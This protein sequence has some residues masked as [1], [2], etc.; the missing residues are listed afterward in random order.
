MVIS[1]PEIL[2]DI[3][4]DGAATGFAQG[5][6]RRREPLFLVGRGAAGRTTAGAAALGTLTAAFG[7]LAAT[8]GILIG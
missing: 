7:A 6:A 5:E 4:L 8:V 2:K 3:V 1:P